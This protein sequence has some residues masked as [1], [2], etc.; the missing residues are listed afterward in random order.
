[1]QNL[2]LSIVVAPVL[3]APIVYMLGR[4]IGRDAGWATL[5]PLMCI[6]ALVITLIPKVTGEHIIF[7]EYVWA[8]AMQLKLGFLLD[9]LSLPTTLMLILVFTA[10]ALYS[11][12]Y[13]KRRIN[14]TS[15]VENRPAYATYYALFM[16]YLVGGVGAVLA[17]NLIQFYLFYELGLVASWALI[18]VYG[19]ANKERVA[20]TYFLWTH[21]GAVPLL[22][23]ILTI[24]WYTGNYNIADIARLNGNPIAIWVVTAILLC[25]L[26]K[27]GAVG[28]HSWLPGAYAEAPAPVSAVLGAT[29]V[30]LGTY[31]VVR[32]LTPLRSVFF[33]VSGWLELWAVLTIV[34]GGFMALAEKDFKRL[35]AF[36]S[37]SQMNYCLLGAFT[38]M[39][40]GVLGAV[41]YSL[42]HG[43]AIALLF[44]VAGSIF[45]RTKTRDIT[46]LGGLATTMPIA[47]IASLVGFF[48]IGGVPPT[49]GFKSKFVLV[50]GAFDRAFVTSPL[51]L[52]VAILSVAA[53]M[54]TIAY[55]LWTVWR[56]FYGQM[57]KW[58]QDIKE[59]PLAMTLPLLVLS[60]TSLILGIWPAVIVDPLEYIVNLLFKVL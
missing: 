40:Q 19:Y 60:F 16:L 9:G 4:K 54:V 13:M 38:H 49:I 34:Y 59:S 27:M 22:L 10:T 48:T 14:E 8:P 43:L 30:G 21:V 29:S 46:R 37:M 55:E 58:L 52:T 5:A 15:H 51:E 36:L 20:F 1:M 42:S 28:L 18:Y 50:A 3:V 41:S 7:E 32:L 17:T 24:G 45:H 31:A 33:G 44:L 23:G 26:V 39:K 56:V 35:I 6:S 53:T 2:L 12:E 57:P 47:V 25:F 11:V